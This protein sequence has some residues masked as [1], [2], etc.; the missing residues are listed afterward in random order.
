MDYRKKKKKFA[1]RRERYF[2][3]RLE[4]VYLCVRIHIDRSRRRVKSGPENILK[5]GTDVKFHTC[6]NFN[7]L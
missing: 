5:S 1:L 4:L 2:H 7:T 6:V 3:C